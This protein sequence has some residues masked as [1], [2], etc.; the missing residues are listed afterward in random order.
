M[1]P[2]L[3]TF[4]IICGRFPNKSFRKEIDETSA[5]VRE[6]HVYGEA[7]S[8]GEIG[9]IQHR[10]LGKNLPREAEKIAKEEYNKYKMV[11]ISGIG[12]RKYF[13]NLGYKREGIYV[14]K[15]L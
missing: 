8:I 1:F 12:V 3:L 14:S 6:I 2:K 5:I 15:M 4:L 10:G 11:V 9:K 7:A 13:Y